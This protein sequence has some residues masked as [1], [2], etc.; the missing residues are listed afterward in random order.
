MPSMPLWAIGKHITAFTLTPI[1]WD[2]S[3]GSMTELTASSY[4]MYGHLQEVSL[5]LSTTLENISPMNRPYANS[6]PVEWD[7]TIRCVELEKSSGTNGAADMMMRYSHFKLT[8]TRGAQTFSVYCTSG[9][10]KMDGT[11]SRVTGTFEL[12]MFDIGRYLSDSAPL[13]MV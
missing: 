2:A 6:V 4:V 9:S 13:S 11:K 5:E 3:T 1:L 10:Y 7:S 8:L 12:K